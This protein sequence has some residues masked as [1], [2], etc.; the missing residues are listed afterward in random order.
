MHSW[1]LDRRFSIAAFLSGTADNYLPALDIK[2]AYTV[3]AYLEYYALDNYYRIS[4]LYV[5]YLVE[6]LFASC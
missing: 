4:S 3:S 1:G 5:L 6:W 2:I